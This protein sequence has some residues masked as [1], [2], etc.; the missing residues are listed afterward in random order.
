ML[1][2]QSAALARILSASRKARISAVEGNVANEHAQL[3]VRATGPSIRSTL[4]EVSIDVVLNK[5]LRRP[6]Q[7]RLDN[8]FFEVFD[9]DRIQANQDRGVTV[10]VW[11]GEEDLWIISEKRLLRD[12]VLHSR[13][14]DRARWRVVAEGAEVRPAERSFP[15]KSLVPHTPRG[16]LA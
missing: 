12:E 3:A 13:T 8:H 7:P 2:H 10:E 4:A 16:K 5:P 6:S 15:H 9:G 1:A 11:G 14:E